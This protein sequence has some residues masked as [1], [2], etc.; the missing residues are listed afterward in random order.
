MNTKTGRVF[1][2]LGYMVIYLSYS[3]G[4][5]LWLPFEIVNK[6]ILDGK[7]IP[8]HS[9]LLKSFQASMQSIEAQ[10]IVMDYN[11]SYSLIWKSRD[12]D[13]DKNTSGLEKRSC[14]VPDQALSSS[15]IGGETY[16]RNGL[17]P[18]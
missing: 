8:V 14:A 15:T 12:C 10:C 18:D 3:G 5:G 4:A 11:S 13:M 9:S 6:T 1:R 7:L 17:A 16:S 2:V